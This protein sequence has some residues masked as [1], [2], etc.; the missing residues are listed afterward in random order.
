[1]LN[2]SHDRE[3]F[4]IAISPFVYPVL[5]T[6]YESNYSATDL[7]N[8]RDWLASFLERDYAL[9]RS[10]RHAL[11]LVLRELALSEMDVVTIFPSYGDFYVSGCV[12]KTIERHCRWSMKIEPATKAV[13]VIHEWGIPHPTLEN[14]FELGFPVIEDCAY[15]FASR[16]ANNRVGIKGN[17]AIYSLSKF[18]PVNYGGIVC[19]L[20]N[21]RRLI[22]DREEV[23]LLKSMWISGGIDKICSMRID[24]WNYLKCLF[25]TIG[26][27]PHFE[28]SMG[29]VP[30][31][32]MFSVHEGIQPDLVKI[33]YQEH[34][35]ESSVYY[36]SSS[37]YIPCHQNL[38]RGS[39][40]YLFQIYETVALKLNRESGL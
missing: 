8:T 35:V 6:L 11:D 22:S 21:G 24:N 16:H 9:T 25:L 3:I 37:V 10:G 32:F 13:L 40:E 4:A 26:V 23:N 17:Y 31:V 14:V 27:T 5:D 2:V 12:T 18:F 20:K 33:A 7:T 19:G 28:L 30:G 29:L 39:M 36:G 34:G 1:M 38:G 15:A